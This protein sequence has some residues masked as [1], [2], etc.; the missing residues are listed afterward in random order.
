MKARFTNYMRMIVASA[1]LCTSVG[2]IAQTGPFG[3]FLQHQ[4][5]LNNISNNWTEIDHVDLNNDPAAKFIAT[6][7]YGPNNVYCDFNLG[8]WFPSPNWAVYDESEN[9]MPVKAN[10]NILI[11][12][13][14]NGTIF[15]HMS[16]STN[17]DNNRT[18]LNH[19]SVNGNPNAMLFITHNYE[20]SGTYLDKPVGIWYSGGNW[21]IYTED[22]STFP[23]DRHFNVFAANPNHSN[24]F[25]HTADAGNINGGLTVIDHPLTNNNPD[26]TLLITHNHNASSVYI[27]VPVGVWY[28]NN[29][30]IIFTQD[31]SPMPD[32]IS[33]N[34]LIAD[35]I[36]N[37]NINDVPQTSADGMHIFPNPANSEF[38]ISY[39]VKEQADINIK[40]FNAEG[41]EIESIYQGNQMPG[42]YTLQKSISELP[43]G[44]YFIIVNQNGIISRKVLIKQ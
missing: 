42:N 33:F 24:V 10:F 41:K 28:D 6:P 17:V 34:V 21:V 36:N 25:I 11:P 5:D 19:P 38:S 20:T 37:A 29:R 1:A 3:A 14:S 40:L 2:S 22:Q 12:S 27:Q 7:N 15:S 23:E 44:S 39:V 4:S 35:S 32:G 26:I 13:G 30:W 9:D 31:E 18:T 8:I 43:A 16:D